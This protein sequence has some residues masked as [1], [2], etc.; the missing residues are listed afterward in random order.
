[1]SSFPNANQRTRRVIIVDDHPMVRRGLRDLLADETD[2]QIIGECSSFSET[3]DLVE[4]KKP[5]LILIDISLEGGSGLELI[6][7][8]RARHPDVKMLVIS[9]HEEELFAE[10][11]LHAGAMGYLNKKEMSDDIVAAIRQVLS[12]KIYLSEQ[13]TERMLSRQVRGGTEITTPAL[14]GLTDR[15]LEI[16]ECIGHGQSTRQIAEERNL[17]VKTVESHRENIKRKLGLNNNI[18]LMQRAFQWVIEQK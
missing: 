3:L 11:A 12:D 15:E 5:D 4:K 9:M 8:I 2:L 10:R 14:G 18:E 16:F 6:K 13:M 17:S 7:Q 1:M